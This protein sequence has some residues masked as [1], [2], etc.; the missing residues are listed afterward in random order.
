MFPQMLFICVL[1]ISL[2]ISY[3]ELFSFTRHISS[4]CSPTAFLFCAEDSKPLKMEE[5]LLMVLFEDDSFYKPSF[6]RTC[7]T[8]AN[9][10]Q[11]C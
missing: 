11:L 5:Q 6:H 2:S 3:S 1:G 7:G 4:K 9:K 8:V 10:V